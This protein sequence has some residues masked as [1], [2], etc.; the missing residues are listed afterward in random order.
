MPHLDS[1]WY[2]VA[3]Q[4][5]IKPLFYLPPFFSLFFFLHPLFLYPVFYISNLFIFSPPRIIF[6]SD[7]C[8]YIQFTYFA[9]TKRKFSGVIYSRE[10]TFEPI[11]RWSS[12]GKKKKKKERDRERDSKDSKYTRC[13]FFSYSFSFDIDVAQEDI[14]NFSFFFFFF[15]L[16]QTQVNKGKKCHACGLERGFEKCWMLYKERAKDLYEINLMIISNEPI[17]SWAEVESWILT[18]CM[19]KFVQI[20]LAPN[21]CKQTFFFLTCRDI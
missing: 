20:Q 21:V 9:D 12:Y 15:F 7:V 3:F 16:H 13:N 1:W 18:P 8:I 17:S 4:T 6:G 5:Y 19:V 11:S 2:V 14:E 10:M